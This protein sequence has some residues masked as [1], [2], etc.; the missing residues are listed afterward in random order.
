MYDD[1]KLQARAARV[2]LPPFDM[3]W[4]SNNYIRFPIRRKNKQWVR[5]A[6]YRENPLLN[7][8]GT[9]SGKIEIY[10]MPSRRWSIWIAKA[11]LPGCRRIEWYRGQRQP[12]TRCH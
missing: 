3:F 4:E 9:P 6:D 8:L 1:M 12:N 2:A 10:S 5:F 7:P 11:F